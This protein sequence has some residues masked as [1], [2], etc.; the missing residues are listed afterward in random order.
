MADITREEILHDMWDRS[1]GAYVFMPTMIDGVWT[2]GHQHNKNI[3]LE[4]YH[5]LSKKADVYFTPHT[6]IGGQRRKGMIADPA[7]IYADLDGG[8]IEEPRLAPSLIVCTSYGHYHAYWY[9]DQ[10]YAPTDWEGAA[11]GWSKEIGADP[12]GWDATQVL[13]MPDT[14]NHKSTPPTSVYVQ[15]WN[16]ER[17]YSLEDFPF[18]EVRSGS[19]GQAEPVPSKAERDHLIYQGIEDDRLPLSARYWLTA[20]EHQIKALGQIDRSKIM[21]GVEISLVSAGYTPYEVFHLM[22]FAGINKFRGRPDRL[23]YEVNKA[24]GP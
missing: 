24:A 8:H 21:W 12:G 4:D 23:W 16:P 10:P 14:W 5:D 19:F 3:N 22:H 15:S 2:E 17:T 11:K 9:L 6:Y 7:V 1:P 20:D 13:R 18:T